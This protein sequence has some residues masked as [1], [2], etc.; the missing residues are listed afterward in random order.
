MPFLTTMGRF[1]VLTSSV[2]RHMNKNTINTD[3]TMRDA[4]PADGSSV[5]EAD[6]SVLL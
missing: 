4:T 5:I 6:L 1:S 3:V 2:D